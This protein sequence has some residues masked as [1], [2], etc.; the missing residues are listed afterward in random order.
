MNFIYSYTGSRWQDQLQAKSFRPIQ[1][2]E[3]P[4]QVIVA[5]NNA[6]SR[7]ALVHSLKTQPGINIVGEA[8]ETD[9]LLELLRIQSVDVIIIDYGLPHMPLAKL[10]PAARVASRS[11]R[12]V[13]MSDD[14]ANARLA[15]SAGADMFIS[16]NESHDRLLATLQRCERK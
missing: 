15:L 14:V 6:E 16:R 11:T 2:R 13:V 5:D 9:L 4:M 12:F 8:E 10:I 7:H 1:K 3:E